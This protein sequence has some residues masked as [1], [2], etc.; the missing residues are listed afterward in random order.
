MNTNE[1]FVFPDWQ[2]NIVN[3]AAT[4]AQHLGQRTNKVTLPLLDKALAHDYQNIVFL[5]VDGM[6]TH[7]MQKNLPTDS[8]LRTHQVQELTSVFPSTTTSATTTL[9]SALYPAEHGWFAWSLDFG[10]AGV[11]Q[12]FKNSDFAKQKLPYQY[13]FTNPPAGTTTYALM[14]DSVHSKLDVK[15]HIS[16]H[17]LGQLCQ[18]LNNL[19]HRRGQKFVY[20]YFCDLDTIMHKT[21]TQSKPTRRL[22]KNLDKKLQKLTTQ[23]PDTLFVMTADHGQIDVQDYVHIYQDPAVMDCLAAPLSLDP[24][25]AAFR[26]KPGMAEQFVAAFQKYQ[27]DFVLYPSKDLI[28]KGV[29]GVFRKADYQK[30]LGDYIAIGTNTNK[31]LVFTEGQE[32]WGKKRQAI[33]RGHHTALTPDEMLVPLIIVNQRGAN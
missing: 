26:V 2:H 5:V 10:K 13:F 18:K 7:I 14:P 19:C 12:L 28:A 11:Q 22:L 15:N 21:G 23:N 31:M 9:L 8:F 1:R 25:A 29:F 30:Y 32:I 4:L 3:L 20:A 24:R 33:Y 27:D 6:G 17:N 16:Y